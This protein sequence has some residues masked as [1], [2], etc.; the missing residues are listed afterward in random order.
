M[1]KIKA[2]RRLN[3]KIIKIHIIPSTL[4]L[5]AT[6]G[7]AALTSMRRSVL[8]YNKFPFRSI[9]CNICA[10]FYTYNE[11]FSRVFLPAL[12]LSNNNSLTA[13]CNRN[14][15]KRLRYVYV[16]VLSTKKKTTFKIVKMFKRRLWKKYK[17]KS[18]ET[19]LLFVV[20]ILPFSSYIHIYHS[21]IES[22]PY[23]IVLCHS[24]RSYVKIGICELVLIQFGLVFFK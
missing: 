15:A 1:H 2:H 19:K 14:E 16:Y 24:F 3:I 8:V 7:S 9:R 22:K 10:V 4:S 23:D 17:V 11:Y 21:A 18:W 13:Q 5:W 12:K 20:Q 6:L